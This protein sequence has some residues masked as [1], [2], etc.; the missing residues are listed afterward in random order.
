MEAKQPYC[1]PEVWGGIECTINRVEHIFRDQLEETGHYQRND[2]IEKFAA[3]GFDKM[4]YP[5]LWERHQP[6]E[7]IPIDW[8]W[9]TG[10]LNNLRKHAIT[11]IAG[12]M[13]HGSG[14][15]YTHLLDDDFPGKL[16][17]YAGMVAQ[18][19]P[20]LEY[21][22]PVNEPLTTARFSGLYGHWYPHH[23][24]ELSC[25]KMVLNQ[26]KGTI[27][28]MKKIRLINPAAKLV[29]TEDLSKIHS[30]PLLAYQADFE[31]Q[32]RWLSYDLL[33]GKINK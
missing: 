28:S 29:Q 14:P 11:P 23:T 6:H 13:H 33:C 7:D 27:L 18:Q 10:Q 5:V 3:L 24:D 21:Y 25:V 1:K 16:A 32:R 26:V 2:D 9:I 17:N 22:T 19:F 20:W 30:T 4:R 12:L 8:R 15:A 31:N